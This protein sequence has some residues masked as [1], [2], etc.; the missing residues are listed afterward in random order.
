MKL[1]DLQQDRILDDAQKL[2]D[3]WCASRHKTVQ[4]TWDAIDQ[5]QRHGGSPEAMIAWMRWYGD[6]LQRIV[7]DARDQLGFG[8][9]AA[10]HCTAVLAGGLKA[11]APASNAPTRTPEMNTN[12]RCVN[13][14]L[15]G[16]GSQS[17][18]VPYPPSRA[19]QSPRSASPP[20][21]GFLRRQQCLLD[22]LGASHGRLQE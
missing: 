13:R 11:C 21:R 3:A 2:F 16:S 19:R 15:S 20:E 12:V 18:Q 9:K 1:L 17:C 6:A 22:E 5:L 4:S 8:C 7:E 14:Q 10:E